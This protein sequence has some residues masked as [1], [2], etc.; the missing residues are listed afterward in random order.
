MIKKINKDQEII[1]GA[2]PIIELLKAKKRKIHE[3]YTIKP[4]P[5]AWNQIAHSLPNYV[6]IHYVTKDALNKLAGTDDHQS[7]VAIAGQLPIRKKFFDSKKEKFILMLDGIQDTRNLGAILRSAYCTGVSGVIITTKNSAP[8]SGS[9]LKASAGLAEH[10]EIYLA[11][12]PQAAIL[13]LKKAGYAIFLATIEKSHNVLNL[14]FNLPL[15][16]VIGNEAT[17]ISKN[18][19]GSGQHITLPQKT[20]DISYNASVAAGILL[21][22]VSTKNQII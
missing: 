20:A 19:L 2:H 14:E 21:F 6:K 8:I 3:I 15:C 7:I 11:P 16:I 4:Q 13:E 9:V 17:G 22:L 12:T 1:F 5:K 18:I 10:L